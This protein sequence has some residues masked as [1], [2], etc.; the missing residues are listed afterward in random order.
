[1]IRHIALTVLAG[2]M[3]AAPARA[4]QQ[5]ASIDTWGG[6]VLV[7]VDASSKAIVVRQG[8]H[9]QRYTLHEDVRL[10]E[11]RTALDVAGLEK[12]VGRYVTIRYEGAGDDRVADRV[13]VLARK[14]SVTTTARAGGSDKNTQP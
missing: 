7:S 14:G 5:K 6:G 12:G 11:G 8:E 4:G 3:I 9:E 13:N 1:M 10:Q 2:L